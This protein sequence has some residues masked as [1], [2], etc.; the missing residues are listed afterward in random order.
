MG[1]Y[2]DDAIDAG[3]DEMFGASAGD[4]LR[5]RRRQ[6]KR[7]PSRPRSKDAASDYLDDL[8]REAERARL[9]PDGPEDGRFWR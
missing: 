6:T 3:I 2:A 8:E 5:A 1:D 9:D 4:W 7:Q